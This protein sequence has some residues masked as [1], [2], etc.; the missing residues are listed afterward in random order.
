MGC[1]DPDPTRSAMDLPLETAAARM[2]ELRGE[3][4]RMRTAD[5]PR[6]GVVHRSRVAVGR[7]LIAL[8]SSIAPPATSGP[9]SARARPAVSR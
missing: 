5:D 6:G 1:Y 7:G 9:T 3:T 4:I 8:G 2:A